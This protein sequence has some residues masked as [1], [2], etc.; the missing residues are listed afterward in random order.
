MFLVTDPIACGI[1]GQLASS[2]AASSRPILLTGEM[3]CG[4]QTTALQVICDME[5]QAG[6][7]HLQANSMNCGCPACRMIQSGLAPDVTIT[8]HGYPVS[9]LRDTLALL[10]R[11]LPA[12][13]SHRYLILRGVE[14]LSTVAQDA[15]LNAVEEAPPHLRIL[16]T[17]TCL[18][19]TP[20]ALLNRFMQVRLGTWSTAHLVQWATNTKRPVPAPNDFRYRTPAHVKFTTDLKLETRF[21][22]L[23]LNSDLVELEARASDLATAI[24]A[25]EQHAAGDVYAFVQ[26]WMFWRTNKHCVEGEARAPA[27]GRVRAHLPSVMKAHLGGLGKYSNPAS[28]RLRFLSYIV[29]VGMLKTAS[30]H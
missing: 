21:K 26:E 27:L 10:E 24:Q 8:G 4:K 29:S 7:R 30:F 16:A 14:R 13:L 15:L 18:E 1:L 23:F 2:P 3:G 28:D 25:V 19:G 9:E 17:A 11:T 12:R 22:D 6:A 20:E 5:C